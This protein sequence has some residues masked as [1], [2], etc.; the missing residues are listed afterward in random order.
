MGKALALPDDTW[1]VPGLSGHWHRTLEPP[2]NYQHFSW[3]ELGPNPNGVFLNEPDILM[4]LLEVGPAADVYLYHQPGIVWDQDVLKHTRPD[5][6]LEGGIV[7][8][9]S[10]PHLTGVYERSSW[11]GA[12]ICGLCPEG[13][14]GGPVFFVGR[15]WKQFPSSW[16]LTRYI[17]EYHPAAFQVKNRAGNP[18]GDLS[19]VLSSNGPAFVLA[20]CFLLSRP[21][22]WTTLQPGQ[23]VL[24]TTA[25]KLLESLRDA[26]VRP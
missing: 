26:P 18:R 11:L 22:L 12:W 3:Y 1:T 4:D 5:P 16:R 8:H 19:T 7:T 21:L 2:H 10:D 9:V 17:M 25:G 14:V 24:R 23:G 20:P 6:N 13:T 15:V